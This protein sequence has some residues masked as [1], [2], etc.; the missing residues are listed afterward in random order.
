[1]DTAVSA[2]DTQDSGRKTQT[3]NRPSYTH[4]GVLP[5]GPAHHRQTSNMMT[6]VSNGCVSVKLLQ[7]QEQPQGGA[8]TLPVP[9]YDNSSSITALA[10]RQHKVNSEQ[11]TAGEKASDGEV[12]APFY[13]VNSLQCLYKENQQRKTPGKQKK[14]FYLSYKKYISFFFL[15]TAT[16]GKAEFSFQEVTH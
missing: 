11:Q 9:V 12:E 13:S 2:A 7:Y 16:R 8:E 14:T 10:R 5:A 15:A 1:M 6:E 3:V 4:T